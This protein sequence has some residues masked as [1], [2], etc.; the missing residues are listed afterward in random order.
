PAVGKGA[1]ADERDALDRGLRP[2]VD[3]E[4]EINAVV[5]QLDDLGIDANIV[6][7]GSSIDFENALNVGL[8]DGARECAARLRLDLLGELI[9][10]EP[11]IAFESNAVDH[12]RFDDR[13]DDLAAGAPDLHVLE[14]AGIDQ[15][16]VGVV[17]LEVIQAFARAQPEIGLNRA[18][19]DAPVA[20]DDD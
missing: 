5:G 11:A 20:L 2:L 19:F 9:V 4:H 16:L 10:L 1:V 13:H 15:G 6:A 17:D 14:Q 8:D 12:R 7:A 18:R 3:L